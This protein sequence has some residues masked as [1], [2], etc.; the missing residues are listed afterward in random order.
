MTPSPSCFVRPAL[1]A[2]H[3]SHKNTLLASCLLSLREQLGEDMD[4]WDGPSTRAVAGYF[5]WPLSSPSTKSTP[6][7][8]QST[9]PSSPELAETFFLPMKILRGQANI[10]K[11]WPASTSS[12]DLLPRVTDFAWLTKEEVGEKVEQGYW[13][14]VNGMLNNR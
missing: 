14:R 2:I 10:Q 12:K 4:I 5:S 3:P 6:S 13:E 7:S 9:S 8:D 11:S 1:Q